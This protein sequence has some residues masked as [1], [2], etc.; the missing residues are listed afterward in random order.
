MEHGIKPGTFYNWVKRL[1]QKGCGG[2]PAP[3]RSAV[4]ARQEIVKLEIAQPTAEIYASGGMAP[5]ALRQMPMMEIVVNN[6]IVR[7]PNGTDPQ[8]MAQAVRLLGEMPC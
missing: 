6:A 1:R 8:L 3:A 4:S 5:E 7:V 2:I